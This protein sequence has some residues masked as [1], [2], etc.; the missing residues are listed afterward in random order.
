[1]MDALLGE[2]SA[3]LTAARIVGFVPAS[4]ARREKR[5]L[6]PFLT[7]ALYLRPQHC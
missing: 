4:L 6:F 2:I 1:M 5:I 3:C 7:P